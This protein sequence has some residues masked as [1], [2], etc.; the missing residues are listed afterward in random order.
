LLPFRTPI[1]LLLACMC[2][3]M[4]AWAGGGT[5]GKG[6]G[7]I[8]AARISVAPTLGQQ[9]QQQCGEEG[10]RE[11]HLPTTT[12][13]GGS[14]RTA[15]PHHHREEGSE[16]AS[17]KTTWNRPQHGSDHGEE[18]RESSTSTPP[19]R[20]GG[21]AGGQHLHTRRLVPHCSKAHTVSFAVQWYPGTITAHSWGVP[22]EERGK[23]R[24]G[25]DED[26]TTGARK[27]KERRGEGMGRESPP[28]PSEEE[29]A[30]SRSYE[31]FP[32]TLTDGE[33]TAR[34]VTPAPSL[35]RRVSEQDVQHRER[36]YDHMDSTIW[37]Y[38][39]AVRAMPPAPSLS[40]G[41]REIGRSRTSQRA[42][43]YD[44]MDSTIWSYGRA[45]WSYGQ[46][47]IVL[48]IVSCL[49]WSTE[50]DH[51]RQGGA[52][53][54]IRTFAGYTIRTAGF[55]ANMGIGIFS[56]GCSIV[57][58]AGSLRSIR[59]SEAKWTWQEAEKQRIYAT[60]GRRGGRTTSWKLNR[61]IDT[62]ECGKD[63]RRRREKKKRGER[64]PFFP[65]T[66]I[67]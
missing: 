35:S 54:R 58:V 36:P 27:E 45:L 19:P 63:G 37:S 8:G 32:V 25:E 60:A 13:E 21:A 1:Y 34:A 48:C 61:T 66:G 9:Q 7:E 49:L 40:W 11:Q 24:Q 17:S 56:I 5:D 64:P 41:G 6:L 67:G 52:S 30:E 57:S 55:I 33:R 43:P 39:R 22:L 50:G 65:R 28:P 12:K 3:G 44:H 47:Y 59:A 42:R 16:K 15:P 4:Y 10:A 29:S 18:Q 20:G 38:G 23:R 53:A 62:R 31:R 2:M 51:K 14:A 26:G 46:Y